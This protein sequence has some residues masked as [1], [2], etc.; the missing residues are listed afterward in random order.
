[1]NSTQHVSKI[2]FT[3]KSITWSHSKDG[4][5]SGFE[6]IAIEIAN[7]LLNSD[8][9]CDN[10]LM[11]TL[12]LTEMINNEGIAVDIDIGTEED[13]SVARR[14]IAGTIGVCRGHMVAFVGTTARSEQN[15]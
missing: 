5:I 7:F 4:F 8:F 3:L 9:S 12:Q 13:K 15:A 14:I 10:V 1:M 6:L 2:I 11:R